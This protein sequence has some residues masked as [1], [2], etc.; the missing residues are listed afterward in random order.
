[1]PRQSKK[2]A[3]KPAKHMDSDPPTPEISPK[4]VSLEPAKG[5]ITQL[6]QSLEFAEQQ[7]DG[8]SDSESSL[9]DKMVPSDVEDETGQVPAL[10]T[11]SLLD[12]ILESLASKEDMTPAKRSAEEANVPS[13]KKNDGD[14]D[15]ILAS[16]ETPNSSSYKKSRPKILSNIVMNT[17]P[18]HSTLQ[19]SL[20]SFQ[21]D[22]GKTFLSINFET[23]DIANKFVENLNVTNPAGT[24]QIPHCDFI[25]LANALLEVTQCTSDADAQILAAQICQD[26]D[27]QE[28]DFTG[29]YEHFKA[30]GASKGFSITGLDE[31]AIGPINNEWQPNITPRKCFSLQS[32]DMQTGTLN[33]CDKT[34]L[35]LKGFSFKSL[36][37][38]VRKKADLRSACLRIVA[39]QMI[40]YGSAVGKFNVYGTCMFTGELWCIGYVDHVVIQEHFVK[41]CVYLFDNLY[42]AP[43]KGPVKRNYIYFSKIGEGTSVTLTN[44]QLPLLAKLIQQT[45]QPLRNLDF[46]ASLMP[47]N[48]KQFLPEECTKGIVLVNPDMK[49]INGTGVN[50]AIILR[51]KYDE[52]KADAPKE[53][54]TCAHDFGFGFRCGKSVNSEGMCKSGHEGED[55]D[56]KAHMMKR[57]FTLENGAHLEVT[58]ADG[59]IFEHTARNE[60]E[61]MIAVHHKLAERDISTRKSTAVRAICRL[62]DQEFHKSFFDIKLLRSRTGWKYITMKAVQKNNDG[63]LQQMRDIAPNFYLQRH[64][65]MKATITSKKPTIATR[66]IRIRSTRF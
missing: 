53:V 16:L 9:D 39:L 38:S 25:K 60:S 51:G 44:Y 63:T 43:N 29:I 59:E 7:V 49:A 58:L 14:L 2:T 54:T 19:P 57:S 28:D 23:Q 45:G 21:A 37:E 31:Q 36:E 13:K 62:A 42:A 27:I 11:N 32:S 1:M 65:N 66:G 64:S 55:R 50:Q 10:E 35:A 3:K 52:T 46:A 33:I 61:I 15:A 18:L 12:G 48:S 24:K 30:S 26:F 34:I 56:V 41:G 22:D 8:M 17:T 47:W 5:L 6:E 4:E 40:T 20:V